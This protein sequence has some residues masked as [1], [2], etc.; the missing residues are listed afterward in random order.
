MRCSRQ[1]HVAAGEPAI[2]PTG[3]LRAPRMGEESARALIAA[4]PR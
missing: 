2:M 4:P 3:A 1:L